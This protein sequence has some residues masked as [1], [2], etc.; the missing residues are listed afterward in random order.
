MKKILYLLILLLAVLSACGSSFTL[1][2]SSITVTR[3]SS[4][5]VGVVAPGL[6]AAPEPRKPPT[7]PAV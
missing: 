2:A 6:E 3:G 1:N 4:V 7:P 5:R